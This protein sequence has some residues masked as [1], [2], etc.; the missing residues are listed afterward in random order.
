MKGKQL[1]IL[2]VLVVLLGGIGLW[3]QKRNQSSWSESGAGAGAKVVEFPINDV[4]HVIVKGPGGELNL[5]RINDE[6]TV[7]ERGDYPANYEQVTGLLRRLWDLKTVQTV[8]VGPSQFARLELVEP[9]KGEGSGT[10]LELRGKDDANVAALVLGKKYLKKSEDGPM[11]MEGFPAGRYVMPLGGNKVSLVSETL[12][13]VEAKPERWLRK[14]FIK[15]ENPKSIALA[16]TTEP[17]HWTV[18]RDTATAEW[19]LEG[20]K[21][22]E[23]LDQNKVSP[24]ASALANPSFKDVLARDAKPEETGLDKPS[25]V[26]IN[27]FD[28]FSYVLK[29]GKLT[30]EAYPVQFTVSA[31]L[32]KERT[33]AKDEKAE[34][35]TRLDEEFKAKNKRLEEKLAAEK[36]L[37]ERIYLVEKFS[38][39]ALLKDRAALLAEKKPE[40]PPAAN[41]PGTPGA[42]A[43]A[44]A[45]HPPISVTTP[46]VSVPSATSAPVPAP[47][48]AK[49]P[50][51]TPAPK[52]PAAPPQPAEPKE[53]A[54]PKN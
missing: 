24:I 37:E 53:N 22:D 31:N 2:V 19:K 30:N 35:K 17:M 50:A 54:A 52:P 16:G 39:D 34:D 48:A 28:E 8:K 42:P 45:A 27:T 51:A 32:A 26:T 3:L 9:G 23:K 7:R 1:L 44:P 15:I 33:P 11:E 36:K 5:V 21:P 46:P 40:T 12:D 6:W 43:P 29:I 14:D 4:T 20:A 25:T 10:L 49:P 18:T 41:A 47:G 38:I 13:D